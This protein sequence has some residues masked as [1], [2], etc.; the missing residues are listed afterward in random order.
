LCVWIWFGGGGGGGWLVGFLFV[1]VFFF[2]VVVVFFA[3]LCFIFPLLN[4][5]FLINI[6]SQ[7]Q[8]LPSSHTSPTLTSPSPH[9]PLSSSRKG[10]PTTTTPPSLSTTLTLEH[11]VLVGLSTSSTTKIGSGRCDFQFFLIYYIL[12]WRDSH[13]TSCRSVIQKMCQ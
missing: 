3:L 7:L 5:L 6:T 12:D 13:S 4:F 11:L 10:R 2:F 1:L 9:C 8:A